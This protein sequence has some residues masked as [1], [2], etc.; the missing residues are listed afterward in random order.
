MNIQGFEPVISAAMLCALVSSWS[1][2]L[3]PD[4]SD[5]AQVKPSLERLLAPLSQQAPTEI[6]DR[7]LQVHLE[8]DKHLEQLQ[9]DYR[10]KLEA[11]G[12]QVVEHQG[13]N[14]G[15]FEAG[16]LVATRNHNHLVVQFSAHAGHAEIDLCVWDHQPRNDT[17]PG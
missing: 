6:R 11:N 14:W 4:Y 15:P 1:M 9:L 16:E 5:T 10:T 3:A 17:C 12:W 7:G 2:A 13:D 8:A